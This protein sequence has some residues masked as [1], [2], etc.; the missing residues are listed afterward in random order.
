MLSEDTD[1]KNI[2]GQWKFDMHVHSTYSDDSVNDPAIIVKNFQ[3]HGILPLVCDHDCIDGSIELYRRIRNIDPNV[4]KILAEEIT[5]CE[6]EIIGLF[7]TDLVPANLEAAETLEIIH[8]QGG[9]ALVPHPF[10]RFRTSSVLRHE[11][12]DKEISNIDIIEG[13]NGR[14]TREDNFIAIHF[15]TKNTKP[16]S[17][18][19]D[20]H[21]PWELGRYW[22][23]LEPFYTPEELMRSL[24]A[25]TIQFHI[26]DR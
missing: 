16:I 14:N 9:L 2:A 13:V 25:D 12:L 4:P 3:K 23:E 26:I 18:G 17:M 5:T 19:S 24:S 7:L 22:L 6:G 15:A 21:H 8:E 11:T 20:A 1:G 10:C